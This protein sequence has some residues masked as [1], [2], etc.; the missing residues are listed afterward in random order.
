MANGQLAQLA[1]QIGGVLEAIRRFDTDPGFEIRP[2]SACAQ[3]DAA[4]AA[5]VGPGGVWA[6]GYARMA[7]QMAWLLLEARPAISPGLPRFCAV[8]HRRSLCRR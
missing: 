8:T 3:E 6:S 4:M 1:D 7:A 5:E 2:N